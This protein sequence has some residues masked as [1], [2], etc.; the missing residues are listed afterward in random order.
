MGGGKG[1]VYLCLEN[2][3]E[4]RRGIPA[5]EVSSCKDAVLIEQWCVV[6]IILNIGD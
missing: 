4:E 1:I 6:D 5:P 3:G 2:L